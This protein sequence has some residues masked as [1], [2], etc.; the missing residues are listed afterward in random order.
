ME[1]CPERPY[2]RYDAE[3]HP[4]AT[5]NHHRRNGHD[6]NRSPG[7]TLNVLLL[8]ASKKLTE[9]C[10]TLKASS[11]HNLLA[12]S[13]TP[14][15]RHDFWSSFHARHSFHGYTSCNCPGLSFHLLALHVAS[16]TFHK[17]AVND[18]G[19]NIVGR[20]IHALCLAVDTKELLRNLQ[21][22]DVDSR[23]RA[24]QVN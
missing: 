9:W 6:K 24:F 18:F 17:F 7:L 22:S 19:P 21:F 1:C 12:N 4:Q 14:A 13:V 2:P 3:L 16:T 5:V 15:R 23:R 8:P 20:V 11:A 10:V